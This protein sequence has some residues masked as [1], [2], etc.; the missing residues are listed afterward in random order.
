MQAESAYPSADATAAVAHALTC[1]PSCHPVPSTCCSVTRSRS[2]GGTIDTCHPQQCT[3]VLTVAQEAYRYMAA[4]RWEFNLYRRQHI[5]P[6]SCY[7]LITTLVRA[8]LSC[9]MMLVYPGW[10]GG[11]FACWAAGGNTESK[12]RQCTK[13]YPFTRHHDQRELQRP[14]A[15]GLHCLHTCS[16][17][18][19]PPLP[20]AVVSVTIS[21]SAS[22]HPA[23]AMISPQP[24]PAC[25]AALPPAGA[26]APSCTRWPRLSGAS[27]RGWPACSWRTPPSPWHWSNFRPWSTAS[28]RS[29]GLAPSLTQ[30]PRGRH[31]R[32]WWR[33]TW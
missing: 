9:T 1:P 14:P 17:N 12:K 22:A 13:P 33:W 11:G 20:P 7:R 28:P 16:A 32:T 21:A 4:T 18:R 8:T 26:T 10:W 15:H 31:R 29:L 19:E 3:G 30:L 27:A 24:L 2:A 6:T 5:F 25:V 23:P